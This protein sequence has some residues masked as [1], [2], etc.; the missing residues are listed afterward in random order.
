[1]NLGDN[2][3]AVGVP[4]VV[5]PQ[6]FEFQRDVEN[7]WARNRANRMHPRG[8]SLGQTKFDRLTND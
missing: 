4:N 2:V 1:M 5:T 7:H 3:I 6:R 8:E